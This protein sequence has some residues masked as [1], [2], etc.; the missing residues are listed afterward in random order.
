MLLRKAFY[1]LSSDEATCLWEPSK[2]RFE[3]SNL[4][5]FIKYINNKYSLNLSNYEELYN[6]SISTNTNDNGC[7]KFWSSL[8]DFCQIKAEIKGESIL[9]NADDFINAQ[10]FSQA[11]LNFAENL[12][13]KK[14][15]E[16]ALYFRAENIFS[17]NISFQELQI[18]VSKL[19]QFLVEIG[20]TAND[21]IALFVPNSIEA[22]VFLLAAASLGAICSFC[23]PDFGV[24][25]VIDRF[26]QIEPILFIYTDKCVYNGKVIDSQDKV[27]E[28]IKNL[29]S[30]KNIICISYFNEKISLNMQRN[31]Q[32]Y[33]LHVYPEIIELYKEKELI[34]KQ[35]PFNH[36]LYIMY[37]SGTTGI[38]KCIVHGA[39]GTLLQH[40]KEHILHCDFKANEKIF[41]YSTC[42]WMM[43]QWL[44]SALA[45]E[46]SLLLY[47]GSPF[48]PDSQVL[49]K[50]IDEEKAQFF[51]TS[52]KYIDSLKKS[53][54]Q[55][56]TIYEFKTLKTIGSTGSPLQAESFDYVYESIK[57]DICLSS[58]S[59]GTD[60][61][62]CFV[63]G[64]PI[65]KVYRGEIQ[66]RGLGMKVEVF[67][68]N[69]ESV[70]QQK[71]EMV[72]SFPFPSQP[73]YF[74]NDPEKIKYKASYFERFKNIWHH[75]DWIEIT[76]H[77][78]III[79]GR[80]D[81]TLNPGGVR[82]G[83]AEIY[84]QVEQ[85]EE[86]LECIAVDQNWKNDNR[87]ILF[88][89]LRESVT[90][91]EKLITDIK[92]ALRKNCSP[93]HVPAKIIAIPDIPKTKSGKIVEIAVRNTIH[94]IEIK[95]K[96]SM[97]NP[98]C[99]A[100]FKNIIELNMD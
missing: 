99:L 97:A 41:Y 32:N 24:Q 47:D 71:G 72:C 90:L 40:L 20:I 59:G 11:R 93:R 42:G 84:R 30:L 44:V 39:G 46:C 75:G 56:N 87:I 4:V 63:L 27:S 50:Y 68:E 49:L 6:W 23:S 7:E 73:I 35:L 57:K 12:L 3:S 88:L 34:F 91:T 17:R 53:H 83:T 60:I 16:T 79:Y 74:W 86:V 98:E 51:G 36:P 78:G 2:E 64:N 15:N 92:S 76:Q 55:P 65:G 13:R 10:W 82:I 29:P 43:W 45:S 67:N 37:S 26:G 85:F 8:W 100:F 1:Y 77:N 62:S 70:V 69:G 96:E 66:T 54:C 31:I 25:G 38:P 61:I 80:S 58:L 5:R 95:N 81:A 28:I 18:Q 89:R 52:A 14:N 9:Q 33:S 19:Q 22:V 21:R 94:N 48:S